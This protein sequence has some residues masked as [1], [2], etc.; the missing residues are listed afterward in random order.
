[1]PFGEADGEVG[2]A[3]ADGGGRIG[4][5]GVVRLDAVGAAGPGQAAGEVVGAME[6]LFHH[7]Y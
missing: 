3:A 7:D 1:M 2:E 4:A 6:R 5:V